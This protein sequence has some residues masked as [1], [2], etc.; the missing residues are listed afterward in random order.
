MCLKE[1]NNLLTNFSKARQYF[2]LKTSKVAIRKA[3]YLRQLKIMQDVIG[4][5]VQLF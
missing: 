2:R 3:I 5:L 4:K 1:N